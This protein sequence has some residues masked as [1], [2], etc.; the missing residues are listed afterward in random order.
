MY[1]T[2]NIANIVIYLRHFERARSHSHNFVAQ[3]LGPPHSPLSINE[4]SLQI[5]VQI[6]SHLAK[7]TNGT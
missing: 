7:L 5:P 6:F 4:I 2:Y 3:L 1:K